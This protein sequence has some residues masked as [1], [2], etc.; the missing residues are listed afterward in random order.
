[1]ELLFLG[2]GAADRMR[3]EQDNDF[4][5]HDNR[6]CS[7]AIIDRHI[8]LDCGPHVLNSL[9][10]A[11]INFAE[12]TDICIT[13]FHADHFDADSF[14]AIASAAKHPIS[15][16]YRADAVINNEL[17]NCEKCPMEP[18]KSYMIGCYQFTGLLSNHEAF[19]Q[20]FSIEKDEKKL[21][22]GL[23][24]AW[25]LGDSVRY[26]QGREY[27]HIILDA[28]VGDYSGDYRMGEHNSIPMIRLMTESMKTLKIINDKT[29]ILL[30]H[31]AVCLHKTHRETCDIV[32]KD[33]YT[34]AYDGMIVNI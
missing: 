28:T 32:S 5:N 34:V 13:H 6:R 16:W 21:F 19:P 25:M 10:V 22:Y 29:N 17:I 14:N 4:L 20:H 9:S 27:S 30:S 12:I 31:L 11:G 33:G 15:L 18:Y 26:M 1:M 3:L 24:G 2:T 8:L 23:D 7:A